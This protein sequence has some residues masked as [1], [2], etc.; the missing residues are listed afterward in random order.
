MGF[1]CDSSGRES[2]WPVG[3][4]G[5]FD[6]WVGKIPWRRERLPT[7]VFWPGEFR[8]LYNTWGRIGLDTAERPSLS[9]TFQ[10]LA[11]KLPGRKKE[12]MTDIRKHEKRA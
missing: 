6:L 10:R 9:F 12:K 4:L 8:G 5:S 1:P 3:D 2:A 11:E 7:S